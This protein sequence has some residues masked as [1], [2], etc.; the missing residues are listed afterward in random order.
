MKKILFLIAITLIGCKSDEIKSVDPRITLLEQQVKRSMEYAYFEGQKDAIGG[1]VRIDSIEHNGTYSYI[2]TKS[3]WDSGDP[4][5][6]VP[7]TKP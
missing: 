4:P 1:N 3:P 5:I 2:W 6:Y 7:G